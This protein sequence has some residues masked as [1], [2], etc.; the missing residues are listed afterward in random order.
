MQTFYAIKF[1]VRGITNEYNTEWE[2]L[3][4]TKTKGMSKYKILST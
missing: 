2:V 4:A 3:Y 1:K